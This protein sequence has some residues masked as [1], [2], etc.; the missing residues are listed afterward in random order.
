MLGVEQAWLLKRTIDGKCF[1]DLI[2][3]ELSSR[4]A[5]G[6]DDGALKSIDIKMCKRTS[7]EQDCRMW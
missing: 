7:Q 4:D 2:W 6:T 3:I 1:V 5:G